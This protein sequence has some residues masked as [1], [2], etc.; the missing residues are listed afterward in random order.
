[1]IAV[2]TPLIVALTL[3]G[4]FLVLLFT[5][6]LFERRRTV[7]YVA[8]AA[9]PPPQIAPYVRTMSDEIVAA[10]FGF[11][12]YAAHAKH[13]IRATVWLS[14]DRTTL[15][16]AG[17]GKVGPI[18][19]AQTWL[20]TPLADGRFLVTTDQND[21]GD[22]ARI[23]VVAR[24][25]NCHFPKLWDVHRT[26]LADRAA[27]VRSYPEATPFES[28]IYAYA[29]RVERLVALGRA[30]YRDPERT[31]WS[32]TVPGALLVVLNFFGQ[33]AG[34]LPQFW[35]TQMPKIAPPLPP[36]GEFTDAP[37]PPGTAPFAPPTP[38]APLAPATPA[39]PTTTA[40]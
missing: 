7:P 39:P 28:L 22:P 8:L 9:D 34:A 15:V 25:I 16:L 18:P 3:S 37:M 35:R 29:Y 13:A 5:V 19:A 1:M 36:G 11:G 21:E 31:E 40:V 27:D 33:F 20:F 24:R 32:Y 4:G 38:P 6:A 17:S 12:G 10:G 2:S 14:P 23:H 30:R 26:R